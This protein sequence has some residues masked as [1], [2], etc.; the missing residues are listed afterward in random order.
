MIFNVH[1]EEGHKILSIDS[2][3]YD[4]RYWL[5]SFLGVDA[6]TPKNDSNQYRVS[7]RLL[8]MDNILCPSSLCTLKIKQPLSG[9]RLFDF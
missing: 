9:Q 7:Y 6:S 4:T 1:K 3:R 2:N 5:E 8:S